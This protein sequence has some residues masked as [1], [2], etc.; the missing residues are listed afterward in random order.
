MQKS[1]QRLL[2]IGV[3][4]GGTNL[5]AALVEIGRDGARIVE[6]RRRKVGQERA[7]EEVAERL[8]GALDAFAITVRGLVAVDVGASGAAIYPTGSHTWANLQEIGRPGDPPFPWEDYLD[9]MQSS[10]HNF[11]RL[12]MFEQPERACWTDDMIV[13]DPLPCARPLSGGDYAVTAAPF[14]GDAV[15]YLKKVE[16]A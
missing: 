8:A 7:P 2:N 11:M 1:I 4:I 9:F 3:D 10:N 14:T 6:Q 5:R 15:L 13:F 16:N 12:W